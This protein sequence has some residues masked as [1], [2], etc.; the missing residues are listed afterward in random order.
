[1]PAVPPCFPPLTGAGTYEAPTRLCPSN[2]GHPSG[3]TYRGWRRS[4]GGSGGI[5]ASA[6]RAPFHQ[7]GLAGQAGGRYSSPSLPVLISEPASRAACQQS[8]RQRNENVTVFNI[9]P[10]TMIASVR[11]RPVML[12]NI[13]CMR[14]LWITASVT[15]PPAIRVSIRRIKR[16]PTMNV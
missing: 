16:G 14:V 1:M 15:S 5:F 10:I 7:P 4:A 6:A 12:R 8:S 9:A 2:G 13:D 11:S 3:S